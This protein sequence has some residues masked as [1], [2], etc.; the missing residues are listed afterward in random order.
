M[1]FADIYQ[2]ASSFQQPI[3]KV[4][5][6]ADHITR[7][8]PG[9]G[10]VTFTKAPLDES[11][12]L[13]YVRLDTDRS[14]PYEESF[15]NLRIRYAET[16]NYCWRRFVCCKE[17]MHAFDTEAEKTNTREKF[18]KLMKQLETDPLPDDRSPMLSSENNTM[19]MALVVLCPKH[20]RDQTRVKWKAQ[21]LTDYDVALEYRVPEA[22]VKPGLMS[23]YYD[24]ALD[25]L[26]QR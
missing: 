13:G 22:F 4:G 11:V 5:A 10:E 25:A 3:I 23:D 8:H 2:F 21:E 7:H 18:I 20:L 9:I 16:L 14:S 24:Q 15:R 1:R 12:T 6:L 19:W 17:L 26:L